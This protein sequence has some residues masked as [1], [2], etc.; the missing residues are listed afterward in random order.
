MQELD[1]GHAGGKKSKINRKTL[2][3]LRRSK[4]R[5]H[6]MSLLRSLGRL[7]LDS[8]RQHLWF[9]DIYT[10]R[11]IWSAPLSSPGAYSATS[12]V[13]HQSFSLLS[14]P[15]SLLWIADIFKTAPKHN[16]A[17]WFIKSRTMRIPTKG[18]KLE[19]IVDTICKISC[20]YRR[21]GT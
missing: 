8:L 1:V 2:T 16:I 12:T 20:F 18:F 3:L 19:L 5:C 10:V 4:Q 9:L 13:Q 17:P 15:L 11:I 14:L 21:F 7:R 6:F